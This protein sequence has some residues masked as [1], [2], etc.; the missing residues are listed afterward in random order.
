MVKATSIL[1]QA[2][3]LAQAQAVSAAV[4]ALARQTAIK[5]VQQQIRDRGHKPQYMARGEIVRQVGR[6]HLVVNR[7]HGRRKN[8]LAAH[9]ASFYEARP[10]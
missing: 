5:A 4:M 2:P 10:V 7:D 3:T 8:G 1:H 9:R 6:L